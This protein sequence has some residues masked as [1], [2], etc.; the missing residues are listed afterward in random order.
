MPVKKLKRMITCMALSKLDVRNV[1]VNLS[2]WTAEAS[3]K[4]KSDQQHQP[5]HHSVNRYFAL[6]C[7]RWAKKLHHGK[8]QKKTMTRFTGEHLLWSSASFAG[9]KASTGLI[10]G[11]DEQPN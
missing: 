9:I 1:L 6:Y 8:V 4:W 5:D 10:V 7:D 2:K 3:N 11:K